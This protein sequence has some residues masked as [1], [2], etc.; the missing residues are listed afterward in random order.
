MQNYSS[1]CKIV[2]IILIFIFALL[3]FNSN[4]VS[5]Q[6]TTLGIYP[7]LI[8]TTIKPGK[9]IVVAYNLQ[10]LGDP[11]ILSLR[12]RPF[13][14]TEG[15][16]KMVIKNEF[17]GP[18][19]FSLDN[20]D[21]E[22]E[23][24]FFLKS[25]DSQQVLL[26]IRVPEGAPEGDYYYVLLAATQPPPLSEGFTASRA[27]VSLGA[28]ILIT[29]TDSGQVEV[30]GRILSFDL[31][32]GYKLKLFDRVWRIFDSSEKIPVLLYLK[33]DGRNFIKPQGEIVLRGNFGERASY[34]IIPQNILAGARRLA[35]ASPSAEFVG[36]F[37]GNYKVSANVSFGEGSPVVSASTSFTALPLKF[38]AALVVVIFISTLIIKRKN[39]IKY[40]HEK[41]SSS[42]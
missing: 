20:S 32:G 41:Q 11:N 7:P 36:F 30:K 42:G 29:V 38:F 19:R 9:S 25:K 4:E 26:R 16:S 15:T 27:K 40:S 24:P 28:N 1:K 22:L 31:A 34:E 5:A 2:F 35:V 12:L 39:V 14:P 3:T 17:E 18:I 33:N 13:V 6:Q 23:K 37:L 8:E 21:I 10:N